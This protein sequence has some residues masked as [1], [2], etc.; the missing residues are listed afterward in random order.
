MPSKDH[1]ESTLTSEPENLTELH[2]LS[3]LPTKHDSRRTTQGFLIRGDRLPNCVPLP[4][5]KNALRLWIWQHGWYIGYKSENQEVTKQWLCKTCYDK[6]PPPPLSSYMICTEKTTTKVID[7][8]ED[9]HQFD[10]S[11]SKL[12][13]DE[14]KKR[15]RAFFESWSEQQEAHNSIFDEEGWRSTYC[16]WV[17]KSNISLRQSTS[18]DLKA[19]L[20][21]QNPRVAAVIPQAPNTTRSWIMADFEN[22]KQT[23]IRSIA[24]AKGKVTI[25]FDG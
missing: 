3:G 7:H 6:C 5:T 20:C 4:S 21:F 22:H 24:V 15:K 18:D 23:I 11:G 2:Q 16:R 10:R 13:P 8:L 19:L 14:S 1:I 17:V 25:S 12:L 9:L